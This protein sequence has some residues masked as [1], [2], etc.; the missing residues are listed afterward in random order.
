MKK[1]ALCGGLLALV[2]VGSANAAGQFPGYPLLG[3]ITGFEYAPVDTGLVATMATFT[4]SIS[5]TTLTISSLTSGSVYAGQNIV[6]AN[7]APGTVIV[8]GSGLTWTVNNSQTV[9]STDMTSGGGGVNPQ[10]AMI[11]M[12][13]LKAY[14]LTSPI[15]TGNLSVAAS[16]PTLSSC[17]TSPAVT[18]GSSATAGAFTTGT[19][20]PTACT[21][22]FATAYATTAACTISAAN[23]AA[24]GVTAYVSAQSA[25]A[26][27]VT[28]SAGTSTAKYNYV[29]SGN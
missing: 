17:G 14:V 8:S 4:G 20:T 19:G 13:A 7:V 2:G 23:A 5:G 6:G 16:L 26:F 28:Q 15:V 21:I 12:Q 22:T 1:L 3:T 9:S 18:A 11:Q 25:S 10:T 29:C 27:T 24:G